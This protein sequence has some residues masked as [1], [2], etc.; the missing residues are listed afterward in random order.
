MLIQSFR[1][2]SPA[3]DFPAWP[4]QTQ[5]GPNRAGDLASKLQDDGHNERPAIGV[6]L[7]KTLE[8]AANLVLHHTVVA[9]LLLARVLE[10]TAH[11]VACVAQEIGVID[12]E[13]ARVD[14][15]GTL[16]L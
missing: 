4:G 11:D 7:Q 14:L 5:R 6:L 9:A 16:I 10:R 15:G 13:A 12:G 8:I 1:Q 2:S 3:G